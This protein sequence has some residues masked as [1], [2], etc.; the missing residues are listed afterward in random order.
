MAK[1]KSGFS[2]KTKKFRINNMTAGMNT[3]SE[4]HSLNTIDPNATAGAGFVQMGFE[5]LN[6]DNWEIINRGGISKDFGASLYKDTG[7]ASPITGLGR[8]KN[9]SAAS[10]FMFSQTT[11]VYKLVSGT[12]T[13]IGATIASGAYT[14]FENAGDYLII[15]DGQTAAAPQKWDG[16]TVSALGGTPP[17]AAKMSLYTQNRL[18]MFASDGYLY[19][20]DANNISAGYGANFVACNRNN[21]QSITCIRKLFVP[22]ELKP[23]IFTAKERSIGMIDGTGAAADPFVFKEIATDVGVLGFRPT[24]YFEQ[25]IAF[26]TPKGVSTYQ[27][28]IKN[29]NIEEKFIS[30]KIRPDFTAL[31]QTTLPLASSWYDWKYDRIGFAVA[32]GSASYP[33]TVYYYNIRTGGWRKKTGLNITASFVD[34]DGTVYTGDDQGRIWKH[35]PA[36]NSYNGTAISCSAQTPYMDFFEPD[37][38]KQIEYCEMTVRGTGTYNLSVASMMNDGQIVGGTNTINLTGARYVWGGGVWT[39]DAN[40]YQ[41]GNAPLARKK[42]FPRGIFKNISFILTNSGANQPIDLI[43]WVIVVRYLDQN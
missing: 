25:D 36:V 12:I 5:F 20:S 35:D 27:T 2:Y 15:C 10:I 39:S 1:S 29:V 33:N 16:T 37:K 26:L 6:M 21:G 13:D 40:T 28:A 43:D 18:F 7:V 9:S 14:H 32:T 31:S 34:D 3:I 23:L 19:Y 42:F 8:Y 38:Y 22:G 24:C 17:N 30:Q 4:G 41:W 11:K